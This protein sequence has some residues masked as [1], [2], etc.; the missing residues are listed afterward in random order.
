MCY[1]WIKDEEKR[2]CRRKRD[3]EEDNIK[4]CLKEVIGRGW[5]GLV[6]GYKLADVSEHVNQAS[7][8]IRTGVAGCKILCGSAQY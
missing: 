4:M 3:G 6:S 7:I 5:G 1:S 8:L 2:C